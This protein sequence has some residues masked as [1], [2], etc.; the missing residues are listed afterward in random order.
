[1]RIKMLKQTFERWITLTI[2]GM[3]AIA[4][5]AVDSPTF[6]TTSPLATGKW[7][8]IAVEENGVYEITYDELAEMGFSNP[9][10]VRVYGVGAPIF[11]EAMSATY[12]SDD[13]TPVAVSHKNN[14]LLFYGE[15]PWHYDLS[16]T[17]TLH[18]ARTF[19]A[20]SS[21]GY[22]L[23]TESSDNANTIKTS[24][25]SASGSTPTTYNSYNFFHHET[26]SSSP[27][28]SGR[29]WLG[30]EFLGKEIR[31][32]F[33]LPNVASRTFKLQLCEALLST[34]VAYVRCYMDRENSRD[35]ISFSMSLSKVSSVSNSYTYYYSNNPVKEMT[36]EDVTKEGYL[37][38]T[39]RVA[40]TSAKVS[41]AYLDYFIITYL[42]NNLLNDSTPDAQLPMWFQSINTAAR[43]GMKNAPENTVVWNINT[44]SKPIEINVYDY[45]DTTDIQA[46]VFACEEYHVAGKYVA[47]DPTKT[48]K[49]ISSYETLEN[50]N[51][52]AM[53]TPNMLIVTLKDFKEQA[54]RLADMHEAVDGMK[55]AVVDQSQVFNEFTQGVPDPMAIR[56]LCKM[57]YERNPETFKYL[58]LMGP[59][60]YDNRKTVG[61]GGNYII[62]YQSDASNSEL[63]SYTTDDFFG[64][65]NN[66]SVYLAASNKPCIAVGRITCKT[67]AEAKSDVDKIIEY[68]TLPDYG[69][70][71]NNTMTSSDEGDDLKY[72][73]QAEGVTEKIDNELNTC[74]QVNKVHNNMYS[75]SVTETAIT[76]VNRTATE[77]K[78]HWSDLSKSGQLFTNYIGH[79][80]PSM[81]TKHSHMWTTA[82]VSKT[83]FTRWPFFIAAGC[84]IARFDSDSRGIG[85]QMLHKRDGGVI[86]IITSSRQV[87]GEENFALDK[88]LINH[89]F[90]Y[91]QTDSMPR[92][93]DVY[94]NGK[95]DIVENATYEKLRTN[96]LRFHLLGDPAIRF[97]YPK[98][99][100]R[101]TEV[102]GLDMTDSTT[103]ASIY[104]QGQVTVTAK[105]FKKD[106][107][108]V[109]TD[110]NGDA[111]ITV[112]DKQRLYTLITNFSV[113]RNA[114]YERPILA[115]ATAR[116]TNGVCT[117]TFVMPED[118]NGLDSTGLI[119]VYAHMD[120]SDEMV[121]G[122]TR[123][124]TLKDYDETQAVSD[125][126]APVIESMYLNDEDSFTD[127]VTVPASS[128]IYITATDDNGINMQANSV[129]KTMSLMLDGGSKTYSRPAE[130]YRGGRWRQIGQRGLRARRTDRGTP[131]ADLHRV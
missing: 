117:A 130:L 84:E 37:I 38:P 22:Y 58:L 96:S 98:P 70:W 113:E 39:Y 106:G 73:W 121:N 78:Q 108:T 26:E 104:P 124:V 20:Y 76:L 16:T 68:C 40:T 11:S 107:E 62:T 112:Y 125:D 14:K 101:I 119:R 90:S 34:G 99:Y 95:K 93:G 27:C 92:F 31:I 72:L 86:A 49:K 12:Q 17:T 51:L 55:V 81:F 109:N 128:T 105:V 29:D 94:M 4:A 120:D 46:K 42:Q 45:S 63:T 5:Q 18:I 61:N 30:E 56:L 123:Q 69:V 13:L 9:A 36:F 24:S 6:Y 60:N 79:A 50:T 25:A 91:E 41:A 114:Y 65:L 82:D 74:M 80:G 66:N 32:P 57:L 54:Q 64:H 35:T 52:H 53:E 85:D 100:F 118:F 127:G 71:R 19:N 47:F 115:Q 129:A 89:L 33:K 97:N 87:Y 21:K 126:E 110:F 122:F 77:A 83:S 67:V 8:K 103:N 88:Y 131:H 43:V 48:L 2:A 111:T 116:V 23:L 28:H 3:I 44:A 75:K 7:V 10:N 15:G 1:M 102:N 59:G